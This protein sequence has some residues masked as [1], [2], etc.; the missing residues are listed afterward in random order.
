[1]ADYTIGTDDRGV[2][3]I[4]LTA[5]VITTVQLARG[6]TTTRVKVLVHSGTSPVYARPGTS[7]AVQDVKATVIPPFTWDDD[8]SEGIGGGATLALISADDAIVS[9][10]R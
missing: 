10:Y 6:I 1:M 4:P 9:V 5:G 7:V 3:E 8:V 2:Y